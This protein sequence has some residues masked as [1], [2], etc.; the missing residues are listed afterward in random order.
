M[1]TIS[2]IVKGQQLWQLGIQ[3]GTQ[4]QCYNMSFRCYL[5]VSTIPLIIYYFLQYK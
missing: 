5:L 2:H 3:R 4:Q 1:A